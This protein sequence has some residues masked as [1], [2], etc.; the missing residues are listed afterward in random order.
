M[1]KKEIKITCTGTEDIAYTEFK[2]L[3]GELKILTSEMETMLRDS[4]INYG[5]TYPVFCWRNK[6]FY[7]LDGHQ[8][9]KVLNKMAQE[10]YSIPKLP[11]VYIEAKNKKEAGEKLLILN[12][13]YGEITQHGATEFINDFELDQRFFDDYIAIE[14]IDF[15]AL[16]G[17]VDSLPEE[18]SR[19]EFNEPGEPNKKNGNYFYID[20]YEEPELFDELKTKLGDKLLTPHQ[21]DGGY[22]ADL[23]KAGLGEG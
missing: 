21:I 4:I 9:L 22:I 12:S 14:E 6:G 3:Q 15:D 5:F 2:E 13:R 20:Y 19:P 16:L 10:G 18:F 1:K 7:I 8:R 23:I 11:T 17:K